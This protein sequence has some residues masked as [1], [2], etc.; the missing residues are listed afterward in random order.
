M[1]ESCPPEELPAGLEAIP[2]PVADEL[3]RLWT[4]AR[5]FANTAHELNNGLQIIA[6]QAEMLGLAAG[7]PDAQRRIREILGAVTRSA[8][9]LDSLLRYARLKPAI[10]HAQDVTSLIR[11]CVQMRTASLAR[12]RLT[13]SPLVLPDRCRAVVDTA[14]FMQVMM[15]L[16]LAC[17]EHAALGRAGSLDVEARLMPD[18]LGIRVGAR[19]QDAGD[20]PAT[21]P[22]PELGGGALSLVVARR[23]AERLGGSLA[24]RRGEGELHFEL[25]LP[26]P[27]A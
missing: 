5:A 21:A 16:L 15:D 2:E 1:D 26:A 14:A 11:T 17:E 4:F 25:H 22:A 10:P 6:G 12:R 19:W 8:A 20:R 24:I 23:L 27:P 18:G 9:D 13:L 3:N 7:A